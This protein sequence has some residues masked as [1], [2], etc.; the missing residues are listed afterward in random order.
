[1]AELQAAEQQAA[2]QQWQDMQNR[3]AAM[4]T[5]NMQAYYSCKR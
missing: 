3:L 5:Q 4:E 1:M 2:L